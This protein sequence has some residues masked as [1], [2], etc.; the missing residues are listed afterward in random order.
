MEELIIISEDSPTEKSLAPKKEG[1]VEYI[2]YHLLLENPYVFTE[3]EFFEEVHFNIREKRHLRISSYS[4]KRVGLAKRYGWGIHIDKKSRIAIVR[5]E[6]K[7]YEKL[8][9]D[10]MVKKSKAYRNKKKNV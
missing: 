8:L 4:L 6:S 1:T 2:K 7:L 3:K 9:I 5:C 10:P